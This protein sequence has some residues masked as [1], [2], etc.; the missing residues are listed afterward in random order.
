VV[1]LGDGRIAGRN[2]VDVGGVFGADMGSAG[3]ARVS[4][5]L[6][7]VADV[8]DAASPVKDCTGR[9]DNACELALGVS[10]V[11]ASDKSDGSS[12]RSDD[13]DMIDRDTFRGGDREDE[14]LLRLFEVIRRRLLCISE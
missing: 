6:G 4:S 3:G 11:S 12:E 5:A 8:A 2:V 9:L 13:G 1:G 7:V 10:A 14:G